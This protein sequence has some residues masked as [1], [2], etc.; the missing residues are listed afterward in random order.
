MRQ[1]F[2]TKIN[3]AVI[4]RPLVHDSGQCDCH[5]YQK[6][7]PATWMTNEM[8]S[9]CCINDSRN[10]YILQQLVPNMM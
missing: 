8:N 5:L 4:G 9:Q 7:K 1:P 6:S 3:V 10:K 2:D